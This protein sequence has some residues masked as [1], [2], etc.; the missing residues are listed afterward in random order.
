M[1]HSKFDKSYSRYKDLS[2]ID[3]LTLAL[4]QPFEFSI[5]ELVVCNKKKLS[6]AST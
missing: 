2:V 4:L 3:I 5:L 6:I 1:N